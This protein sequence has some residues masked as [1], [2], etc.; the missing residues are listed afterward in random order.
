[1]NPREFCREK[2]FNS[3]ILLTYNFDP[4]FFE[5]GAM[6]DLWTGDT[7]DILVLADRNQ[8]AQPSERWDGQLRELGR[9]YQLATAITVGAFHPKMMLRIGQQGGAVWLG[10]GNLTAGGWGGNHELATAWAIGPNRA[11]DGVW[12]L[13]L[14]QRISSWSPDN[15]HHNVIRRVLETPWVERLERK[16]LRD[17][18]RTILTSHLDQSLASQLL[19]RWQGRRFTE[20]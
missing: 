4:I 10:S 9:R 5:R 20:V 19:A 7:G 2:G 6:R 3:A 14:L 16:S 18:G 8:I 15:L 11:D 12:L 1:M 17:N 13:Q